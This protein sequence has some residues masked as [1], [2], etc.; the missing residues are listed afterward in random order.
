MKVINKPI[1]MMVLFSKDGV[2]DPMQFW[3]TAN[4]ESIQTYKIGNIISREKCRGKDTL[5][6]K[7]QC[8]I[9][10]IQRTIDIEYWPE[11]C[12]WFLNSIE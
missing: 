12:K 9:N 4:D 10:E 8:A 6:I 2:P 5:I 11:T 7:C 1:Q 3:I